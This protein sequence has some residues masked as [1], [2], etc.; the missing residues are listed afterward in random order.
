MELFVFLLGLLGLAIL[1]GPSISAFVLASRLRR[2]HQRLEDLEREVG[3]LREQFEKRTHFLRDQLRQ[4]QGQ[5][6]GNE[7]AS[8]EAAQSASSVEGPEA[9]KS[10]HLAAASMADDF[11]PRARIDT[12]DTPATADEG[13]HGEPVEAPEPTSPP[14]TQDL[15]EG[16][17]LGEGEPPAAADPPLGIGATE[18]PPLEVDAPPPPPASP[19]IDWEQWIGVRGAAVLGGIVLALAAI[20]LL[21]LSIERGLI[22][23]VVRV[24]IGFFSGV[25]AIVSAQ[26]LRPRGYEATANALSGAGIVILYGATWAGRVL[27]GLFPAPVSWGLMILITV[28]A[29]LLS[30]RHRSLVIAMLGLVGGFLT[31]L[32][33][34]SGSDRPIG[35][36][37]YLLLL[38]VSLLILARRHGWPWLGRLCLA[39]TALYQTVWLFDRMGADQVLLGLLIIA[40]FATLFVG[41]VARRSAGGERNLAWEGLAAVLL[42]FLFAL[43]FAASADLGVHLFP[44]AGLLVLL[45]A[46]ACW[47]GPKLGL[48][49]LGLMAAV[50]DLTLF[51]VWTARSDFDGPLAWEAV[52]ICVALAAIFHLFLEGERRH[53]RNTEVEPDEAPQLPATSSAPQVSAT[54]AAFFSAASFLATTVLLGI[55]MRG[56]PWP[57]WIAWALLAALLIR[58]SAIGQIGGPILAAGLALG[59]GFAGQ[60]DRS[61]HPDFPSL[62]TFLGIALA[63]GIALQAVAMA[64]AWSAVR[65]R[66]NQAAIVFALLILAVLVGPVCCL[67]PTVFFT[68]SFGLAVLALLAVTRLR[69]GL[70]YLAT[71]GLLA[72][73]HLSWSHSAPD[74]IAWPEI[75]W[76]GMVA[77]GLAVVLFTVWPFLAGPAFA[78]NRIAWY[79]AALAGPAWF[80]ALNHLW[81]RRWGDGAIGILPILL[82]SI[83]LVAAVYGRGAEVGDAAQRRRNLVWFSAVALGFISLA[84]PLQLEKEWVTIGWACVGIALLAL[85]QRLDHPGLKAFALL[86]LGASTSRLLVNPA[87]LFYHGASGT[88]ILNWLLYT[89]LA[90]A[91]ALLAAAR[92]LRPL[93]VER[94]RSW[95]KGL[96]S[97]QRP[98]GAI[99]CGLAAILVVFAWINL[100]IADAF[101]VGPSLALDWQHQPARD[102]TLSLAWVLYALILLTLG[103]RR[104]SSALRWIS[105]TF[106]LL[107]IAKVFLHDLGNLQ[108]LYR[109]ASLV[110]LAFSLIAVSLAYQRFVFRKPIDS[111]KPT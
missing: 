57:W 19:G 20:L 91:V 45:S 39:A 72:L 38:D 86:L 108:D 51:L 105:L 77:E 25:G 104:R 33:L 95:E 74:S 111:R 83:S 71:M 103:M 92:I 6:I 97:G 64:P 3:A 42:P 66:A 80:L 79:G 24:A 52:A 109:V 65:R 9:P 81:E 63:T 26:W 93:E 58:Q 67:T 82:G 73:T 70:G 10:P 100:T 50:A 106:L 49:K 84:V 4:V 23:P 44:M 16:E 56:G 76:L 110:G 34:S 87:L 15:I 14:P 43:H 13:I 94:L 12:F 90:P 98:L 32:L 68:T 30:S 40:V 1:F 85:W 62:V 22:P 27:Y 61:R 46:A 31:P 101:A 35:L 28:A 102:L 41:S 17:K 88:P 18:R 29:C 53:D 11:A 47:L 55:D 21:K 36:F 96:Y 69:S 78:S 7:S 5:A 48:G 60:L 99:A 54:K 59:V 8:E 2:Q 107:A 89:Y 37:S 75:A